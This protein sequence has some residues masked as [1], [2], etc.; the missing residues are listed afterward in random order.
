MDSVRTGLVPLQAHSKP[1]PKPLQFLLEGQTPCPFP[2][3]AKLANSFIRN[4][5]STWVIQV[6]ISPTQD[7]FLQS[8]LSPL[9]VRN[10]TTPLS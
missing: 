5:K 3:L 1:T 10:P 4:K 9:I 7:S 2:C 6:H 8:C